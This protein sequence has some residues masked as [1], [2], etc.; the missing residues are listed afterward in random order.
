[1]RFSRKLPEVAAGAARVY[2]QPQFAGTPGKANCFGKSVSALARQFGSLSAAAAALEFP[3]VPAL[4]NAILAF[5]GC[6]FQL[7][8]RLAVDDFSSEY[9]L[10]EK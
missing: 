7:I 2:T 8:R 4:Q 10:I 9:D 6:R 1:M 5:C 3:S